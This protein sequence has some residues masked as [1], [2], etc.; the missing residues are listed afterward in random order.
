MDTTY[1]SDLKETND[2]NWA[3]V[4]DL[5]DTRFKYMEAHLDATVE[6]LRAD[7]MKW[8]FIYWSETVAAIIGMH[9]FGPK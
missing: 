9:Y 2:L 8:M 1:K 5:M 3:R 7:L 6:R 4:K